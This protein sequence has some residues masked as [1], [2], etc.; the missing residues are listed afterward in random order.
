MLIDKIK[1]NSEQIKMV[2]RSTIL[3]AIMFQ[4]VSYFREGIFNLKS[5]TIALVLGLV[6]AVFLRILFSAL[7]K[8]EAD[9][10]ALANQVKKKAKGKDK[11]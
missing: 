9:K 7:A 11:S 10:E 5:I 8:K 2:I 6:I 3:F 4:L 1:E